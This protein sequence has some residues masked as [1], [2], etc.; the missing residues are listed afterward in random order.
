[1]S[2]L[3]AYIQRQVLAGYWR[4]L[5]VI[6]CVCAWDLN[7]TVGVEMLSVAFVLV[8]RDEVR[9]VAFH[10]S[11]C[12]PQFGRRS[13]PPHTSVLETV[14]GGG[15]LHHISFF[16]KVETKDE[17]APTPEAEKHIAVVLRESVL[18]PPLFG[19]TIHSLPLSI[20]PSNFQ[21]VM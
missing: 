7:L 9:P 19:Y 3:T 1:M 12:C 21:L 2:L 16:C 5:F 17:L 13:Y 18:L 14:G 15:P 11:T 10:P 20:F 4:G 6:S 8:Q